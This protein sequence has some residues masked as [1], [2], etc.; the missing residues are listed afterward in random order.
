MSDQKKKLLKQLDALKIF[1]KN[2]L[3]RELQR[4]IKKKLEKLDK[5][6]IPLKEKTKKPN[7]RAS[8]LRKYH[9]YLRMIRDN[10][11]NLTYSEIRSQFAKRKQGFE[12]S[13]PDVIWQNPSP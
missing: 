9:R 10:F 2:K 1:P 5:K 4:Q 3:V 8:K 7:Q 11:P 13:I 6:E 12:V